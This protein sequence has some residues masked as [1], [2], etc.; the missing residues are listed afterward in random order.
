MK[1]DDHKKEKTDRR[2]FIKK[3]AYTVPKLVILG[4]LSRPRKVRADQTGGPPPPPDD[5]WDP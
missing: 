5:G 1:N 4:S 2:D 3:V